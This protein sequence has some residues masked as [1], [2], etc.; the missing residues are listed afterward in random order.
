MVELNEREFGA[1]AH[2]VRLSQIQHSIQI[3]AILLP[4]GPPELKVVVN[5]DDGIEE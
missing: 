4:P 3:P 5:P 2:A 1:L